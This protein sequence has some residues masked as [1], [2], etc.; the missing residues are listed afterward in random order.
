MRGYQMAAKRRALTA[1][2]KA[3]CGARPKIFPKPREG[4]L[5]ATRSCTTSSEASEKY[6]RRLTQEKHR[7]AFPK[8]DLRHL[9]GGLKV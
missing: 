9:A 4:S 2:E 7:P 3:N 8:G 6:R 1:A 5:D